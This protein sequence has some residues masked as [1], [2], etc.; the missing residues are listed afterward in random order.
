MFISVVRFNGVSKVRFGRTSEYNFDTD[1]LPYERSEPLSGH[2]NSPQASVPEVL[3]PNT[4]LL[5][6]DSSLFDL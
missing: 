1:G 4:I 3:L 5:A 6:R 2:V